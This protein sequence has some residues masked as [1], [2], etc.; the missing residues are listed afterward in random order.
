MKLNGIDISYTSS[1]FLSF[2]FFVNIGPGIGKFL[3]GSEPS[4]SNLYSSVYW[5][6]NRI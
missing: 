6:S 1:R 5:E 3:S 4:Q 2:V